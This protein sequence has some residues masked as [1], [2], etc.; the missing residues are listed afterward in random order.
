[1]ETAKGHCFRTKDTVSQNND[2]QISLVVQVGDG[3]DTINVLESL[4]FSQAAQ[5][6]IGQFLRSAGAYPGHGVNIELKAKMCVGLRGR[7]RTE[8]TVP[9]P[10]EFKKTK[11]KEW[12]ES[13]MQDSHRIPGLI[14]SD[15]LPHPAMGVQAP[16]A[17]PIVEDDIPF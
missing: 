8:N 16:D 5:F 14:V 4:T 12:I 2:Q 11:I 1:M 13:T 3:E 15:T 7:C 9:K 17:E 6:R 10:G